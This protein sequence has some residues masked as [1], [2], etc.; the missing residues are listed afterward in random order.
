MSLSKFPTHL[1]AAGGTD[2]PKTATASDFVGWSQIKTTHVRIGFYHSV[3][4]AAQSNFVALHNTNLAT[5]L[6]I[7]VTPLPRW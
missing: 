6:S 1:P 4:S 5:S 3:E 2:A 7:Q